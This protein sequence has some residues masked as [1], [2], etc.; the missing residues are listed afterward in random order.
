MAYN[1]SHNKDGSCRCACVCVGVYMWVSVCPFVR[2]SV[3]VRLCRCIRVSGHSLGIGVG[4]VISMT[5]RSEVE[6][7]RPGHQRPLG[8]ALASLS[9][10]R[11]T[12]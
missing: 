11:R 4:A 6:C 2:L 3:F 10:R 5:W 7:R 1:E 8:A 9:R 12:D